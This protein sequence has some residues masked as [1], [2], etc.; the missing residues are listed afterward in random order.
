L[1]VQEANEIIGSRSRELLDDSAVISKGEKVMRPVFLRVLVPVVALMLGGCG[2]DSTKPSGET[3]SPYME[4]VSPENVLANLAAS[5]RHR[6]IDRYDE[7]IHENFIFIPTPE[8]VIDFDQLNRTEDHGS[9]QRMFE[10][11]TLIEIA[12]SA[13]EAVPSTREEE[14]P[15]EQGYMMIDVTEVDITVRTTSASGEPIIYRVE[16]D[17]A[18]FIF[19][20]DSTDDQATW[21]IICQEDRPST[22]RSAAAPEALFWSDLKQLF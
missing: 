5:Y 4:R 7:Q 19:H 8:D 2:G 17:R 16:D 10:A 22:S 3:S 14:Y 9:T 11:A 15:P 21:K 20:P 12:I 18:L 1:P 6:Q 13:G